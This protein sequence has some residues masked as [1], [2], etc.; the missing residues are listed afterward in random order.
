MNNA[1]KTIAALVAVVTI[2]GVSTASVKV[3][4]PGYQQYLQSLPALIQRIDD[5]STA[6]DSVLNGFIENGTAKFHLC[7][8]WED[9]AV[10]R[11]PINTGSE[12]SLYF[13]FAFAEA[14]YDDAPYMLLP[15]GSGFVASAQVGQT[16]LFEN[17]VIK[18]ASVV[19][20]STD[21]PFGVEIVMADDAMMTFQSLLASRT[22]DTTT[23]I[24]WY[25]NRRLTT[26]VPTEM[27][28]VLVA[29]NDAFIPISITDFV[30]QDLRNQP[31]L[32]A[33]RLSQVEAQ[34]LVQK[35]GY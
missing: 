3:M 22:D 16:A 27:R 8:P 35:L 1:L 20:L 15:G 23:Y 21:G 25:G 14:R 26:D 28:A 19:A 5:Y 17:S 11:S 29:E 33:H 31:I 10:Y 12:A 30:T 9:P 7:R 18:A 24:D 4:T 34:S 6:R 2:F 32:V 13:D